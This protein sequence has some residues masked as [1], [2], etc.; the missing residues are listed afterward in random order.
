MWKWESEGR[1]K[2]VVGIIHN[3]YEHHNRYA[4]VI[5][6]LRN[7]QFTVITGDLPGHGKVGAVHDTLLDRYMRYVEQLVDVCKSQNL[8]YFLIAHGL[9][10]L[11]LVRLL[12]KEDIECAG[13][14][15]TSPWLQLKHEP[16]KYSKVFASLQM[17]QIVDHEITPPMLTRNEERQREFAGDLTYATRVSHGW[18]RDVQ[19]LMRA[20]VNEERKIVDV[21]AAV[22]V[23]EDDPIADPK[24]TR[25]WVYGQ[26]LSESQFKKW[27][28]MRHD[29]LQEE[30]RE[31][32]MIYV[33]SFLDNVL[34]TNGYIIGGD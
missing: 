32:V 4:W 24:V 17:N 27:P 28:F 30:R 33:E 15:L 9:G 7:S 31:D 29:I 11:L 22:I 8:P 13:I 23:G 16:P 5:Q 26:K 34:R 19:L 1:A 18:F 14:V 6:H 25:D 12:Q 20:I 3:A 2:A 21:P 10:A